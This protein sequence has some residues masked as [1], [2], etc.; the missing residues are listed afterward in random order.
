[1]RQSH[2]KEGVDG[3]VEVKRGERV[4][5]VAVV[6]NKNLNGYNQRRVKKQCTAG[7]EDGCKKY[8]LEKIKSMF[9]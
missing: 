8:K 2:Q 4:A 3:D 5:G 9:P 1:V 6:P 7:E